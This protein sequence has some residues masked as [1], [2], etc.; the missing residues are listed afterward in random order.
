[1]KLDLERR[2]KLVKHGFR[3]RIDPGARLRYAFRLLSACF[4][5][6][7]FHLKPGS[8][9]FEAAQYAALVVLQDVIALGRNKLWSSSKGPRMPTSPMP[10]REDLDYSRSLLTDENEDASVNDIVAAMDIA[11]E[12]VRSMLERFSGSKF[13]PEDGWDLDLEAADDDAE[14]HNDVDEDEERRRETN[15]DY[16]RYKCAALLPVLAEKMKT[17][18]NPLKTNISEASRKRI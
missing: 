18:W 11:N 16:A 1:V 7:R 5:E 14:R 3:N 8:A 4:Q 17:V 13:D 2:L 9:E 12:G 10:L 6:K 15:R